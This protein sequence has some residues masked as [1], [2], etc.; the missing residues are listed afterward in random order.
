MVG[1]YT[2]C[3]RGGKARYGWLHNLVLLFLGVWSI[4]FSQEWWGR[5][6][7]EVHDPLA[8]YIVP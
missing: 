3:V 2:F 7:Y 6:Q 8:I 1:F 5:I 4:L